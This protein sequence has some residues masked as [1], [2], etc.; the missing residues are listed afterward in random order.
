MLWTTKTANSQRTW[1]VLTET[2]MMVTWRSSW[3]QA[4]SSECPRDYPPEI[5]SSIIESIVLTK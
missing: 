2:I 1:M 3:E 4:M 5:L